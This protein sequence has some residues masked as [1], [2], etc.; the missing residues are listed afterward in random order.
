[1]SYFAQLK[2]DVI[3]SAGNST[4]DTLGAG[5][6]FTG[7]ST[8]GAGAQ[9]T[10]GVAGLQ[11][12]LFANQ[13]CTVYVDQSMDG[14]NWDITDSFNY[15]VSG[16]G[17]SW[18]VQ[19]TASYMRVRVKNL[20][21]SVAADPFRLQTCLCPI[22]E[23]LPRSLCEEGYLK[24]GVHDIAGPYGVKADV[25]PQGALRVA[26]TTR[27]A[28]SSFGAA[29]DTNFWTKTVNS[30]TSTSTVAA[31]LLTLATNPTGVGSGNSAIVNS[32]RTA[33]YVPGKSNFWR[34]NV[35][36][37]ATTGAVT[38]R[39]GPFDANDGYYFKLT[40][41]SFYVGNRKATSDSDVPSGSFNGKIGLN[42]TPPDVNVHTYEIV[43]T[44]VHAYFFVDGQLL[45]TLTPTTTQ[46]VATPHLK[47]GYE[48]TNGANTANNTLVVFNGVINRNGAALASPQYG[49]TNAVSAVNFKLGP[50]ALN[51]I[52]TGTSS[53]NNTI[54]TVYDN[55][56]ATGT[57]LTVLNIRNALGPFSLDFSGLPF[58]IGLTIDTAGTAIPLT[59]LYE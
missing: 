24:V 36:F 8:I 15:Y 12:N 4:T 32:V 30:G 1:M 21:A 44:N 7:P 47:I 23:A 16:A 50:G 52:V 5:A 38:R 26:E 55:T 18:T 40:N 59:V 28:G 29:F 53:N 11:I 45:H 49:Y 9:S 34:S 10:L 33:R 46:L 25:T 37:P 2:Q 41:T 3:V 6:T 42:Y 20:N 43:W 39:I 57:I 35:S 13:N 19:A 48:V 27:L 17:N 31:N 51:R 56:T 58:S 14:S 54:I 22:V